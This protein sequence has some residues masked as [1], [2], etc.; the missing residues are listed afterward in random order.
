MEIWGVLNVT[1][2]SFSDGGQYLALEAALARAKQM[3]AEGAD[4]IDV[5]GASSRPRGATYGAGAEDVPVETEI[6]RVVPVVA[7]LARELGARVSIDTTRGA[8]A[9]AA[10]RA[11]AKIVNDVSMGRDDALLAVVAR[12]DAELVLMH[13]RG[14]GSVDSGGRYDDVV[15]DVLRELGASRERA[16][17]AGIAPDRV[18][19]DPGLGFAKTAEQSAELL[20]RT[21]E[22]TGLGA[23]VLVGASRKSFLGVLAEHRGE[24]PRPDGRLAASLVAALVAVR[25][26]AHAVRVHDVE[27]TRQALD[28]HFALRPSDH[29]VFDASSSSRAP[30]HA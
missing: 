13:T 27:E 8:T 6:A 12:H 24:R 15:R 5:G 25:E 2:D 26:G 20:A 16:L 3:L 9:E 7:V 17:A 14:D 18:W 23:R 21:H 10:L 28:V 22:L 29:R 1:P 4:V 19:L 30:R 11:G